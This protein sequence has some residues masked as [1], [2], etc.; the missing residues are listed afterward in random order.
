MEIADNLGSMDVRMGIE[1]CISTRMEEV[2]QILQQNASGKPLPDPIWVGHPT[3]YPMRD[4]QYRSASQSGH[5]SLLPSA[6]Q[7]TYASIYA[8]L[9]LTKKPSRLNRG[10]GRIFEPSSNGRSSRP[11]LTG[12]C[13]V[14][15]SRRSPRV[16][17]WKSVAHSQ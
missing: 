17:K 10:H 4:S 15:Y 13:V 5:T 11:S 8:S 12:N 16:G 1:Q 3:V 14:P 7:A 9:P 6:E 2:L